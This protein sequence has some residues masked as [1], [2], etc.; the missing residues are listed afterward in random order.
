[1][2]SHVNLGDLPWKKGDIVHIKVIAFPATLLENNVV[3]R[4]TDQIMTVDLGKS[5]IE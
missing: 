4:H 1:M 3:V 5:R 2:I